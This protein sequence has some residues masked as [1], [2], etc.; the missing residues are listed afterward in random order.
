MTC[1]KCDGDIDGY[2]TGKWGD[3]VQETAFAPFVCS[4]C[5]SL[6]L[7]EVASNTVFTAED[8]KRIS[9]LDL[10]VVM[11]QNETLWKA[12]ED[13]RKLILKHPGRRPVLR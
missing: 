5:G 2:L 10:E 9:G 1:P 6:M 11:R 8:I 4:W 12:I 7:M 13:H 3:G